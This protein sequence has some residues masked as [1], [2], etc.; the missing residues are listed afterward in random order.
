MTANNS[1]D[2]HGRK[3]DRRDL[4][5]S[6]LL[7]ILGIACLLLAAQVAITPEPIWRVAANMLSG[8][9]PDTGEG[10]VPVG[11]LRDE[12]LTPLPKDILTPM[13][14]PSPA[15]GAVA[16]QPLEVT[17]T[18]QEVVAVPTSLPTLTPRLPTLTPTPTRTPTP[19]PTATRLP[20]LTPTGAPTLTPSP[21]FTPIPPP[22]NTS[23][24]PPPPTNTPVPPTPTDTPTPTTPP[25]TAL[26]I[27]PT[28]QV[29]TADVDVLITGL[30]FQTGCSAQ[31]GTVPLTV[32]LCLPTTISATVPIDL[33]AG[34]YNLTVT[35]PD[36]QS[37]T[38]A[39]AYTAT[40]PIPAIT[41]VTPAVTPNDAGQ[42]V[43]IAGSDFRNTGAPGGLEVWLGGTLLT[44]ITFVSPI[45]LTADVSAGMS[46][47]AY[48]LTV[49][50]PGP[51][52]PSGSLANAFSVYAYATTVTCDPGVSNCGSA[53]GTPDGG[54][55]EIDPG[56][57][58]TIDFG[59]GN[60]IMNGTGYD[61]VFYERPIGGGIQLD[62][63]TIEIGDG[64][65]WYTVF[66]WDGDSGATTDVVG[67]NIDTYASDG[68]GELDNEAI[69]SADLYPRA[70]T[71]NTGI[72]I[73]IG[74]PG[75]G[76]PPGSYH[77]VRISNP[78]GVSPDPSEVDAVIRLN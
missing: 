33:V 29:N 77:L 24:P 11:P 6:L 51:T 44:N 15:P 56:E 72:A 66:D 37:D 28:T 75:L 32:T 5:V 45:T 64:T 68:D 2:N 22:T 55:A 63:V 39:S 12:A 42:T 47:G 7:L 54:F 34:F 60:G 25:P 19:T 36:A 26:T 74:D 20:T 50:N 17:A 70:A 31:L 8:V 35:N 4:L 3:R 21:T 76:I 67:T 27:T 40:N 49:V 59:A 71:P 38:L 53:S 9:N 61:M 78:G 23:A 10:G 13:G 69:P 41:S 62:Y 1:P 46:I 43:T 58:L 73:D 52:N 30:D 14:T 16:G 65:N 48:N 57:T 18:P